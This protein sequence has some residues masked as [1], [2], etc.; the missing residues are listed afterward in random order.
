MSA[1]GLGLISREGYLS[2]AEA[3]H[4]SPSSSH[5]TCEAELEFFDAST[6]D[7]LERQLEFS[8][9]RIS[10]AMLG[11]VECRMKNALE[12]LRS[13]RVE[14]QRLV[15][16]LILK[17]N[18]FLLMLIISSHA[19]FSDGDVIFLSASDIKGF[20]WQ[21]ICLVSDFVAA[22]MSSKGI[23]LH[24]EECHHRLY[25]KRLAIQTSSCFAKGVMVHITVTVSILHT[26]MSED[27]VPETYKMSQLFIDY[28]REWFKSE[29]TRSNGTIILLVLDVD[30]Y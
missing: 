22:H 8:Q 4:W 29:A 18:V 12:W 16:I 15:A 6:S 28:A 23:D 30:A 27:L 7:V 5:C 9:R 24:T 20:I 17:V 1:D 10:I 13:E 11:V 25:A 14:Y 19:Y 26:I 2:E 3:V 21:C